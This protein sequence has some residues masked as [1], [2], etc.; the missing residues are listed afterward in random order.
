MAKS[1]PPGCLRGAFGHFVFF[2]NVPCRKSKIRR[3]GALMAVDQATPEDRICTQVSLWDFCFCE[4]HFLPSGV[5]AHPAQVALLPG[6]FPR[7]LFPPPPFSCLPSPTPASSPVSSHR[8]HPLP[9]L[10]TQTA[11]A[12]LLPWPLPQAVPG[13]S[14]CVSIGSGWTGPQA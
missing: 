5:L 4:C 9:G 6:S 7:T 10:L 11:L 2:Y 8:S 14:D 12:S 1:Q 3:G 13:G